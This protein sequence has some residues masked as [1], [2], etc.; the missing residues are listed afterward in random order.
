[1]S[2]ITHETSGAFVLGRFERRTRCGAV[3]PAGPGW[4]YITCT[5]ED[6]LKQVTCSACVL[7]RMVEEKDAS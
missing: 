2:D 6:C 3:D 4:R 1:M 5:C 7:L